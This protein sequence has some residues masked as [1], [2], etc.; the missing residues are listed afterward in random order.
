ML[1][2]IR[3]SMDDLWWTESCLRFRDLT[4]TKEDDHWWRLHDLDH[5]HLSAE[6]Q[7]HFE[8]DIVRFCALCEDEEQR[9]GRKLTDMAKQHKRFTRYTRAACQ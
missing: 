5:G 7:A 9:N 1:N 6:Q 8:N 3:P 2:R 4:C